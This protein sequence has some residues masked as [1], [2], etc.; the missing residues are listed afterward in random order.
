MDNTGNE[1]SDTLDSKLF[2]LYSTIGCDNSLICKS[3]SDIYYSN[4]KN[5]LPNSDEFSKPVSIWFVGS[6]FQ[7]DNY[8]VMFVGKVARGNVG[9]INKDGILDARD[10]GKSLFTDSP[11]PYW[12]YTRDIISGLY[13]VVS[14]EAW[15]YTAFSNMLKCNSGDKNNLPKTIKDNCIEKNM[16]I[17][18]EIEILKPKNI[19]FY[20]SWD[21]D[22]YIDSYR[23]YLTEFGA[24]L[25]I[26]DETSKINTI[27]IG[28]HKMP[29]WSMTFYDKDQN[30]V[31]RLLRTGHP[32][33]K[34][35]NNFIREVTKWIRCSEAYFI[36][37]H[38]K[39]CLELQIIFYCLYRSIILVKF[40]L[41]KYFYLLIVQ[42][43]SMMNIL[44][45]LAGILW[46]LRFGD[47]T[48]QGAQ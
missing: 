13:S 30:K 33:H 27:E 25:S 26:E 34:D 47:L 19:V 1:I 17:W 38:F 31:M 46:L 43:L 20:T 7:D 32:Q 36:Q 40:K 23:N 21:Y 9:T 44:I 5:I 3:C 14:H 18:K 8:K 37:T 15:K 24:V 11:W 22:V 28:N 16:V 29:W 39:I 41:R 12:S 35:K 4:P 2:T 48:R 45:T 6:N 10:C 42:I